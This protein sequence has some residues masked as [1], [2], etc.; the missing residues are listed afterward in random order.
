MQHYSSY[1]SH[2]ATLPWEIKNSNFLA[3]CPL[4]LCPA[5][6]SAAYSTPCFVKLFSG[7]MSVNLFAMYPF[8]YK[9]SIKILYLSLNTMLIVDKH[10]NDVCSDQFLVP[11]TDCRSK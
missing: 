9:L 8:K 6:F 7:N 2:V 11:S 3:A 4:S 5:T 1:L 10:C